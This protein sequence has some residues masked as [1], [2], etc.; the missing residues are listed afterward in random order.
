MWSSLIPKAPE[1]ISV[2]EFFTSFVPD[3]FSQLNALLN[4]VDLSFLSGKDFRMQF[5]IDGQVYSVAFKNAK[6]LEVKQG[7]IGEPNITVVVSEKDWRDA[8]TGRFNELADGLNG[9]PTAFID[10]KRYEALM[11]MRGAVT[12]NLKKNDGSILP[13]KIV[14]NDEEEPAATLNLDMLDGL[15]LMNKATNGM[16]LFMKGKIKFTGNMLLLMKLQTLV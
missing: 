10:A 11:S 15:E 4:A 7:S 3:Q 14:F 2:D 16:A 12:M 1:G 13:L 9:D 8:V 5:D 6:D